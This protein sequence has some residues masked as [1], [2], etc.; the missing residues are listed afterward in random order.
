M[1]DN[2]SGT[3]SISIPF[4]KI[5][6]LPWGLTISCDIYQDMKLL[7]IAYTLEDMIGGNHE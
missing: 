3:P 4:T 5:D 7:N 6:N 1:M 2:F